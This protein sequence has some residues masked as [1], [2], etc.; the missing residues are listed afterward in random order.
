MAIEEYDRLGAQL[1]RRKYHFGPARTYVLRYEGKDYDSKAIAGVAH[2]YQFPESGPLI[3]DLFTGGMAKGAAGR[4]LFDLGFEVEAIERNPKEWTLRECEITADAYFKCLQ[5]KLAGKKFNRQRSIDQVAAQISRTPGSVDYK[6]QNIDAALFSA[7]LPRLNISVAKNAQK[8][9][10]YVVLDP[11][12]PRF[13]A[14]FSEARSASE[15]DAT[16]EVFVSI[17]IIEASILDRKRDVSSLTAVRLD[18]SRRDAENRELGN[19]GEEWVV[20][21]EKKC[22]QI[23]GCHELA[24]KVRWVSRDLGDGLGYDIDSFEPDGT[25]IFIEVKT[26]NQGRNAPFYISATELAVSER[27]RDKYRI[28]RLFEFSGATKVYVVPGPLSKTLKMRSTAYIA[29]PM[30]RPK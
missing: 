17:P 13:A 12:A 26:T 20:K 30:A 25:P 15:N 1:Y 22:L 16:S 2:G 3:S 24:N 7:Q 21:A 28:Y 6:F 9:L 18:F 29:V 27:L 4:R 23:A 14:V 10:S 19:C 8:L 11:L 5:Q